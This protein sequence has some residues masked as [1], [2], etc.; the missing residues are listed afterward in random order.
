M[1]LRGADADT[2]E[3]IALVCV[4]ARGCLCLRVLFFVALRGLLTR[5]A[6][7]PQ[8][9]LITACTVNGRVY[10]IGGV[11]PAG[12]GVAVESL[13]TTTGQWR[14][15]PR[16]CGSRSLSPSHSLT[17]SLSHSLTRSLTHSLARSLAHSLTHWGVRRTSM[18]RMR[19]RA[20][21]AVRFYSPFAH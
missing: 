11:G 5:R 9:T 14:T 1:A 10:V 18:G 17:L 20:L 2:G 3:Q 6:R 16:C 12:A 13:D 8:R 21:T 19:G 4:C 7:G 15:E